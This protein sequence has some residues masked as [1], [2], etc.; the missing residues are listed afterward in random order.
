MSQIP[1]GRQDFSDIDNLDRATESFM[2]GQ[3]KALEGYRPPRRK[4]FRSFDFHKIARFAAVFAVLGVIIGTVVFAGMHFGNTGQDMRQPEPEPPRITDTTAPLQT[5][6]ETT[7]PQSETEATQTASVSVSTSTTASAAQHTT[8]SESESAA[9]DTTAPPESSSSSRTTSTSTSAAAEQHHGATAATASSTTRAASSTTRTTTTTTSTTARSSTRLTT[10]STTV[11]TTTTT[12]TTTKTTPAAKAVIS[13]T[14]INVNADDLTV[15]NGNPMQT[16]RINVTNTG[17]AA[18][19][20]IYELKIRCVDAGTIFHVG[21]QSG[22]VASGIVYSGEY[23]Y[24]RYNKALAPGANDTI[25]IT[26][27]TED[28]VWRC[29]F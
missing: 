19:S 4:Y 8:S 29:T 2:R 23:I 16:I 22:N 6:A 10:R 27:I 7:A 26:A 13:I 24:L 1:K 9:H 3:R 11:S 25:T 15:F 21:C 12:T 20:G 14:R 17:D 5:E 18:L 28:P